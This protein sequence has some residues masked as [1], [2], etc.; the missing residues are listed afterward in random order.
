MEDIGLVGTGSG[1]GAEVGI[2]V[3]AAVATAAAAATGAKLKFSFRICFEI[4][5][6]KKLFTTRNLFL[7][8]L[9]RL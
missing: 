9:I 1:F 2:A 6:H 7:L 3:A 8:I 5:K 4:R